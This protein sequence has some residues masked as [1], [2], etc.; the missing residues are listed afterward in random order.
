M[1]HV[2]GERSGMGLNKGCV[3]EEAPG[4]EVAALMGTA[5]QLSAGLTALC[6]RTQNTTGFSGWNPA[7]AE[8]HRQFFHQQLKIKWH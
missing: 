2:L 7:S 5:G 1:P 3:S 4:T 8:P 6:E